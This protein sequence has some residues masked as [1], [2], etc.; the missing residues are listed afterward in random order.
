MKLSSR[1]AR[2]ERIAAP[3]APRRV[4]MPIDGDPDTVACTTTGER[5]PVRAASRLGAGHIVVRY[6]DDRRGH[7]PRP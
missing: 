6:V 4:W 7:E 2:L 5:L 1:L 3:E